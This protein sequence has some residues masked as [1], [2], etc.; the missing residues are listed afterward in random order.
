MKSS[1]TVPSANNGN[2]N[3]TQSPTADTFSV[4]SAPSTI[5]NH[6]RP[7]LTKPNVCSRA[8]RQNSTRINP[9]TNGWMLKPSLASITMNSFSFSKIIEMRPHVD[10]GTA[11][12]TS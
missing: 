3:Y 2:K 10:R 1:I 6:R 11:K 8:A 4:L 12:D 9:S 7:I 5:S